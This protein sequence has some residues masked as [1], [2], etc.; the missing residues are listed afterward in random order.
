MSDR[1]E[2]FTRIK[3]ALEPIEEKTPYP[4]WEDSLVISQGLDEFPSLWELFCHKF[5]EVN[6]MPLEGV[7]ALAAFLK[8]NGQT[9][10]YCDP[11]IA[12]ELKK[13]PAFQG[14]TL[15]TDYERDRMDDYQFGITRAAGAI[16]ETGTIILKDK[17]TSA[18]LGALSPWTHAAILEPEYL[19]P[20][21]PTALKQVLD[22]DPSVI[23]VTGPSK[24]A[25]I[26][27]VLIEG[28]HGPGV[29]ICC[30]TPAG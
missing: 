9:T 3:T 16:A 2:I 15:I 4:E 30:L 8:E 6:G 7:E 14:I 1:E 29:Q 18:R 27:G 19:W 12:V 28:V 11:S 23:L 13:L 10:G 25:D 24:T 22:D 26:E 17:S 20:D 5:R 21:V